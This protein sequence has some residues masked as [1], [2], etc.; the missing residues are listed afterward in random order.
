MLKHID[1]G[2]IKSILLLG[3][4][5]GSIIFVEFIPVEITLGEAFKDIHG[6]GR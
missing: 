5:L 2:Q 6:L 3:L 4:I 1:Q